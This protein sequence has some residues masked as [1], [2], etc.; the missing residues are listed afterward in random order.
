MDKMISF[1]ELDPIVLGKGTVEN[2]K[3]F[4]KFM[5]EVRKSSKKKDCFYCKKLVSSFCNSHSIPL[6][7]LKNIA[8]E[9]EV[10]NLNNF[11]KFPILDDISGLQKT[12]TFKF[13]CRECDSKIFKEYESPELYENILKPTQ[14]M[15]SQIALKTYLMSIQ[16]VISNLE[17]YKRSDL[18]NFRILQTIDAERLDYIEFY[19]GYKRA[20][21]NLEKNW[22]DYFLIYYKKLDYTVPIAF[23]DRI[24]LIND[25]DNQ[26]VNDMYNFNPKY[27]TKDLHIC[28]FP[29][30]N[31]TVIMMF[32]HKKDQSRYS[33]FYREFKRRSD[34]DKLQIINFIIV[35]HSENFFLSPFLP[36]HILHN[37]NLEGIAKLSPNGFVSLKNTEDVKPINLL[38]DK[39]KYENA[40]LIPNLLL[41]DIT[42]I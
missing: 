24:T 6:F 3:K 14:K 23:Q 7:T 10:I 17:I 11:I 22:D 39:Y 15:L 19:E 42:S 13:I 2:R 16:K 20:K 36:D 25:L 9:G 31:S 21:K 12:G 30:E 38:I 8:K 40:N 34:K 37:K 28:V 5:Q 26:M 35:S 27:H 1:L 29:L 41:L 4:S 18:S 32:V 33:K